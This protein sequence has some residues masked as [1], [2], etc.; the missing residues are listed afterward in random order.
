MTGFLSEKD[1]AL[2][3]S[4]P[5]SQRRVETAEKISRQFASSRLS[6]G[7]RKIA[8]DIFR[9]LVRD[10]ELRVRETLSQQ[11]KENSLLPRDIALALAYDVDSVALP[12]IQ[13][14]AVLTDSDLLEIVAGGTSQRQV[15]VA[16]RD[17]L[18]E[19]VSEALAA[20]GNEVAA[21]TLAANPGAQIAEDTYLR[22]LDEYAGNAGIE[23]AL[24]RRANLPMTVI[25][26]L[27]TVV[28]D[29][30]RDQLLGRADLTPEAVADIVLQTR[31]KVTLG[32]LPA[33][34]PSEDVAAL[35][36]QLRTNGRLTPSIMLHALF[37]GDLAFF[38]AALAA[39][40]G[41]P[42]ISARQLIY[43]RGPLGLRAIF[44]R[45]KMP[46]NLFPMVR[47]AMD[48]VLE[49]DY[50]GGPDDRIRYRKRLIERM[51]TQ[52]ESL[53][54]ANFDYLIKRL[55][56]VSQTEQSGRAA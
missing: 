51:L 37:L 11:L 22:M 38:E 27:V 33:G 29:A 55:N 45:A 23:T 35:V 50:D 54:A 32:M 34:S 14:S 7:E 26:R 8:E 5:S 12:M 28:S 41:L 44:D 16:R 30:L 46:E 56:Q 21:G 39:I 10:V 24:V 43:D 6:P 19:A 52:F 18:T 31:E 47:T 1:V 2:L 13:Y 36:R 17:T 25:E 20:T 15:A 49:T 40:V 48:V 4:D 53:D 42:V 9:V 3:L